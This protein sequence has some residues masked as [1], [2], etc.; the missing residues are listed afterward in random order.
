[1]DVE[2]NYDF[3]VIGGGSGGLSAGKRAAKHGKKVCIVDFVK[4]SPQGIFYL[5]ILFRSS[6]GAWRNLC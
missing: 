6:L 1:M 3:I 2:Y 5:L 4:P